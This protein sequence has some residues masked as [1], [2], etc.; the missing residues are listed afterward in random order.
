MKYFL[1]LLS[2]A[3][4]SPALAAERCDG[5]YQ[6]AAA[7]IDGAISRYDTVYSGGSHWHRLDHVGATLDLYRLWRGLPDLGM[8]GLEGDDQFE[9]PF[10]TDSWAEAI[11]EAVELVE[12]DPSGSSSE[13][14]RLK[15]AIVLDL[16]TSVRRPADW[17]RAP[18]DA[19]NPTVVQYTVARL[20]AER[21][22][23]DWLQTII[24]AS[25]TPWSLAWHLDHGGQ[26]HAAEYE[27]LIADALDKYMAGRGIEWAVAAQLFWHQGTAHA[28]ALGRIAKDIEDK[29]LKCAASPAEYAAH[30]AG[31]SVAGRYTGIA[32]DRE[33]MAVLP[34]S[35][36]SVLARNAAM[37][38]MA[39]GGAVEAREV[40]ERLVGITS[41]PGFQGWLNVART[42]MADSVDTLIEI[43]RGH[44]PDTKSIRA[45]NV[46]SVGDLLR[47]VRSE[48]F[49]GQA[50]IDILKGT[51]A[52][53]VALGR[54]GEAR[55][56]LPRLTEKMVAI[57]DMTPIGV[58]TSSL[59][60]DVAMALAVSRHPGL[61][62]WIRGVGSHR[63][64]YVDVGIYY[65]DEHGGRA[66]PSAFSNGDAIQG[67]FETWL[68]LPQKWY[69]FQG[70]RG[71]TW[72]AMERAHASRTRRQK[73]DE[74][75]SPP[76]IF[77][78]PPDQSSFGLARLA[79]LDEIG[80]LQGER[81]LIRQVSLSLLRWADSQSGTWFKAL[82]SNR[83]LVAEALHRVVMLNRYE[84]GGDIDGVPLG[85]R[86]FKL[87]H[88]R[89]PRSDW[90]KKTPHWYNG[91]Q[92]D[93]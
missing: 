78:P 81:R 36:Q 25:D 63:Y 93:H 76:A 84:S 59:P 52:R 3:L 83:D 57:G 68:L 88:K 21:P 62:P 53:L 16:A 7:M 35:V 12:N 34:W 26:D 58:G 38:A 2:M 15:A 85:K 77:P 70:M 56:L 32:L 8:R 49:S 79:A 13:P 37:M 4:A 51:V 14:E 90:A 80:Q 11:A 19:A 39:R 92:V 9:N 48:A 28:D 33:R 30:A 55:A 31:A 75:I 41:E 6:A 10:D 65:F 73:N 44:E 47:L 42:Y 5:R 89:F 29:V 64:R 86:A 69:R 60:D 22:L 24:T 71:I 17:W 54:A 67:D 66:L 18:D 82:L 23:L 91:R 43:H 1:F 20:A 27:R 40:L 46:L 45:L 74:T 50:E 61:S 72:D 87:L